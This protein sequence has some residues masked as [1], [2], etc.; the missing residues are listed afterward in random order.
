MRRFLAILLFCTIAVNTFAIAD[1]T[2]AWDLAFALIEKETR[3]TREQL[4]QVSLVDEDGTYA[5]SVKIIDHPADEDGLLVGEMD[6]SGNKISLTGPEKIDIGEQ[7][8][9]DLKNCF[10]QQDCYLLLADVC[11]AWNEKLASADEET[12]ESIYEK[13]RAILAMGIT[14]PSDDVIDYDTAYADAWSK[15]IAY[16]GWTADAEELFRLTIS[17]YYVLDD[18]PVYF[19]YFEDHSYFEDDYSTDAAMNSYKKKLEAYFTELGQ[20]TPRKIGVVVSAKTGKLVEIPMM[21]YVPVQFHYLDFLIRTDEAV[22]SIA[23]E[24]QP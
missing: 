14:T 15:L 23:Q 11:E 9:R 4:E 16:E 20:Q 1:D 12:M 17:A 19:F 24:E 10:N 7:I 3:Y 18:E 21:D 6:A 5:F 2:Q 22:A 8:Q 13:Y